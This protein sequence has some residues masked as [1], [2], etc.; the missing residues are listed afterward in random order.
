MALE[1]QKKKKKR[2]DKHEK[3]KERQT[4]KAYRKVDQR[5]PKDDCCLLANCFWDFH[6]IL[7]CESV[8]KIVISKIQV[9]CLFY[10]VLLEKFLTQNKISFW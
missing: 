4:W 8:K 1:S 10:C 5:E 3:T 6:Y 7:C 9:L 2:K